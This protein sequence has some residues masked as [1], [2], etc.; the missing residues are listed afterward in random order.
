MTTVSVIIPT[1]NRREILARAL[2]SVLGQT[3]QPHEVWVV[4]DGST[5]GTAQML[6][7]DYPDVRVIMQENRGVSAARNAGISACSGQWI[8][9]LDS[10]DSWLPTKLERQL[11]AISANPDLRLCHTDEIWIR[12]GVRINP[13]HKHQKRGGW[14]FEHCLPL[15]CI[16]PSSVLIH[17]E[18]FEAIGLF[19]EELVACED[20]DYWLRFCSRQPVL[21]VDELLLI[22]TGGHDDQLSKKHWGMDRFRMRALEKLLLDDSVTTLSGAERQAAIDMLIHKAEVYLIG[23]RKRE[24][25]DEITHYEQKIAQ[26]SQP[27]CT[28]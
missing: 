14:I 26:F 10:D 22:K 20:Y 25:T 2:D 19:D 5:D 9:L 27:R 7:A 12:N 13:K 3:H 6:A 16:S 23:A 28:P 17:R 8:A 1:Y 24:K 4:D 18:V 15:C 11:D 21:Y